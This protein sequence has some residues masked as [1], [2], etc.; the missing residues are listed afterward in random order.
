MSWPTST[1]PGTSDGATVAINGRLEHLRR[2]ALGFRKL[3][4]DDRVTDW[5]GLVGVD[6][7][8]HHCLVEHPPSY[9]QD[10]LRHAGK[11]VV[12]VVIL[13]EEPV[14]TGITRSIRPG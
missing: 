1:G 13:N 12:R 10:L 3:I 11:R 14:I 6:I 7:H 9:V 8:H 2:S 5:L 4:N